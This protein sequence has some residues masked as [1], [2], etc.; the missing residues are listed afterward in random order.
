MQENLII[1][2]AW[3][4]ASLPFKEDLLFDNIMNSPVKDY[5]SWT[6]DF[7]KEN[8]SLNKDEINNH[9]FRSDNFKKEHEFNHIL[10]AG[11]SYTWGVGLDIE[12]VWS[13][14]I[15]NEISKNTKCSGFFNIGI[16]GSSIINQIFYIFKYC[17]I[18]G[19]PNTI[20]FNI[21]DLKRFYFYNNKDKNFYE[22]GYDQGFIEKIV[23]VL[24]FQYY[25][26]L[27]QYCNT[28]NI[29]LY[30]FSWYRSENTKSKFIS[31]GVDTDTV[32][33]NFK[34]FYAYSTNEL[35]DFVFDYS[36]NNKNDKFLELARDTN[37]LGTAYH[38]F[39]SHFILDKFNA[40]ML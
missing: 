26:I 37:H 13:K 27:E 7:K 33:K 24:S 22:G 36:Q 23:E 19:N 30:S 17:Q 25:Y 29:K 20:F 35:I 11:C 6:Q 40:S 28:N 39:W 34:T 31:N 10:F 4:N 1:K 12:E 38:A 14:T 3:H 2:K 18:Y 8:P 5:D 9:G 32:L 21:P 16:P 15:Y